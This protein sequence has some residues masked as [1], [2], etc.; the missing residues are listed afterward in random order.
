[1]LASFG[2][3]CWV[4]IGYR[5]CQRQLDLYLTDHNSVRHQASYE[6]AALLVCVDSGHATVAIEHLTGGI[7][8]RSACEFIGSLGL[9]VCMGLAQAMA[10]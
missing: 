4:C 10:C 9:R 2:W 6:D 1:M 7:S 8:V 5:S 3:V